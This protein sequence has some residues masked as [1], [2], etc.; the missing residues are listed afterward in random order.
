MEVSITTR[1]QPSRTEIWHM[2]DRIAKRYDLLNHLLSFGQ[3]IRWRKKAGRF[4]KQNS[5]QYILDLATGTADQ[6]LTLFKHEQQVS[7][8]VGTDLAKEMLSI[9]RQKLKKAN[10]DEQIV[11]QEGDVENIMY[12]EGTFDAVTI[13][14]GIRNTTRV[15]KS[16][17]EM[18]RVLR[19]GGRAI[20]LEFSL[21]K[22]P[23]VKKIYLLYFRYVLPVVGSV[24]SGDSYAYSYLNQTVETFPY[25][26]SFCRLMT[27]AGFMGVSMHSLTFGIAAIYY[28]DKP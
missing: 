8:A 2:F 17:S 9:G 13:A 10:L 19:P 3:D 12:G 22:N 14:F 16:L 18:Y 23:V 26:D 1:N 11:L 6:I 7:S 25:G 5:Q 28:G 27:Q 4:L 24:I 21:P 15:E 20:I